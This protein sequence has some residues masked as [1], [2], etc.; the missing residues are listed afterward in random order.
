MGELSGE[1]IQSPLACRI[2]HGL[3]MVEQPPIALQEPCL[4]LDLMSSLKDTCAQG[5]PARTSFPSWTR[6]MCPTSL[7]NTF[8]VG[9]GTARRL[10]RSGTAVPT[11]RLL[12]ILFQFLSHLR[13]MLMAHA[14]I[15]FLARMIAPPRAA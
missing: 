1:P 3:F 8:W 9:D 6:S 15:L 4:S 2:H 11:L 12:T 7:A 10:T 5:T 14:L 13:T